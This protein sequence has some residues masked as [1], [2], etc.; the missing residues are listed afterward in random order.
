ML[1]T[2]IPAVLVVGAGGYLGRVALRLLGLQ[3]M[4]LGT[5]EPFRGNGRTA[6]VGP[7]KR[8]TVLAG[9]GN[10]ARTIPTTPAPS[11]V[12]VCIGF[13]H[14]NNNFFL[15]FDGGGTRWHRRRYLG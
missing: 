2:R 10:C 6:T 12:V 15:L 13:W 9:D 3:N 8:L 11:L 14:N 5:G 7:A 1:G 4:F